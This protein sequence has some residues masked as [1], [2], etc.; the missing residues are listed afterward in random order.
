MKYTQYR[1]RPIITTWVCAMGKSFL[2]GLFLLLMIFIVT[3][4]YNNFFLTQKIFIKSYLQLCINLSTSICT[5]SRQIASNI[6]N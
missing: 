4:N 2:T 5:Y 6:I 3:H 1:D